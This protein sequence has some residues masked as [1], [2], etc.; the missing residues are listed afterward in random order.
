MV[1]LNA[2]N[3]FLFMQKNLTLLERKQEARGRLSNPKEAAA[4]S[5]VDH[6]DL[7]SQ[8]ICSFEDGQ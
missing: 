1:D 4:K 2:V 6:F 8:C 3:F 7:G 5:N